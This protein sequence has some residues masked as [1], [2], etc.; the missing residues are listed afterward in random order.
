LGEYYNQRGN[1]VEGTDRKFNA[2]NI[3]VTIPQRNLRKYCTANYN[4]VNDIFM[5]RISERKY[6][7]PLNDQYLFVKR[8][9]WFRYVY[10]FTSTYI[11]ILM[12]AM[13]QSSED[14]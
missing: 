14:W 5:Y 6:M 11:D 4:V 13:L 9:L 8:H 7:N 1:S 2:E 10:I 3:C 12:N